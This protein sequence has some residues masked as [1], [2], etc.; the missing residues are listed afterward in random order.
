MR[1]C[2]FLR[3]R[4]WLRP[5]F[6]VAWLRLMKIDHNSGIQISFGANIGNGFYVG[7]HGTIIVN[8]GCTIGKNVNISQDVTL[9]QTNRGE[10]KGV[11]T[12]GDNVYIGPGVKIIGAVKVGNNVAIGANAVVTHDVPDGACVGGVPAKI[13]SMKGSDGYVNRKI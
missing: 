9:G 12:I 6:L 4:R 2:T 5:V 8:G 3:E 13:L 11:P 1:W 7:H 10:R